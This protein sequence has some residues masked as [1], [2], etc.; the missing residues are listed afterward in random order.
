MAPQHFSRLRG[1]PA[2]LSAL[3]TL[4]SWQVRRIWFLLLCLTFGLLAAVVIASSLPLPSDVL[5]TAGLR[6]TLRATPASTALELNVSTTGL[7]TPVVQSLTHQL[8]PLFE[9]ALGP[10]LTA[11]PLALTSPDFSFFPAR[12]HTDLT[13]YATSLPQAAPHL[14][15]LQGQLTHMT[16]QPASELEVLLTPQTA[17]H[18]EIGGD[19]RSPRAALSGRYG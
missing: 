18:L 17:Q 5:T 4:A 8:D 12:P 11:K 16:S 19:R 10:L 2:A 3:L 15:L 6:S 9:E 1:T 7:S 14:H 13:I